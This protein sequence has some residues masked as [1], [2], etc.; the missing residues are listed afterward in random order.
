MVRDASPR[1]G[2]LGSP[3]SREQEG[4]EQEFVEALARRIEEYRHDPVGL[5]YRLTRHAVEVDPGMQSMYRAAR[6]RDHDTTSKWWIQWLVRAGMTPREAR[7]ASRGCMYSREDVLREMVDLYRQAFR[8]RS[9]P[10]REIKLT[11]VQRMRAI[12]AYGSAAAAREAALRKLGLRK[13]KRESLESASEPE[14]MLTKALGER[15]ERFLPLDRSPVAQATASFG[16]IAAELGLRGWRKLR[17]TA[18]SIE[19]LV[20]IALRE[21]PEVFVRLIH[22]VVKRA[23]RHRRRREVWCWSRWDPSSMKQPI[24]REEVEE[25]IAVLFGAGIHARD[26]EDEGFLKG[27]PRR[28]GYLGALSDEKH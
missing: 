19:Q 14:R 4:S 11:E 27:L 12:R 21:G 1:P 13:P 2:V 26:L 24:W 17:H 16:A 9:W 6:E 22:M 23:V 28:N 3:P 15:L 7:H 10:S 25:I 5:R 18:L 8:G 20:F